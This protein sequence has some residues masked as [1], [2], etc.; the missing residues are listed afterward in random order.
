M[1]RVSLRAEVWALALVTSA[2]AA[3]TDQPS[4]WQQNENNPSAQSG[5]ASSATGGASAGGSSGGATAAPSLAPSSAGPQPAAS[6][7]AGGASAPS[8]QVPSATGGVAV[9][10]P[11]TASGGTPPISSGGTSSVTPPG[12]GGTTAVTP[13]STDPSKC[14]FTFDVTTVTAHGFYGPKNVGA[15]WITD[16]NKK[17]VKTLAAWG[18]QRLYNATPWETASGG[19]VVD[20]VTGATR[21]TQG[22]LTAKWDCTDT[23]HKAVADGMYAVNVTFAEAESLFTMPPSASVQFTKSPAGADVMGQD[24]ANF[25]GMHVHLTIP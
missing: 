6:G 13:P 9:T 7:G 15:I 19:N 17:F 14:T 23:S 24:T 1:V 5:G 12:T 21:L 2:C 18:K 16:A 22:P 20:V 3:S 8:T 11:P 25:T 10:P 4:T